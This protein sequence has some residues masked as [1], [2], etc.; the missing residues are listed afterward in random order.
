MTGNISKA[1]EFRIVIVCRHHVKIYEAIMDGEH[2]LE[3]DALILHANKCPHLSL[4]FSE[5]K[6]IAVAY[7]LAKFLIYA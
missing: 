7:I 6:S 4:I 5:F 3:F 1:V 2:S